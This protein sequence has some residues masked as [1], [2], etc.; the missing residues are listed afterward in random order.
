MVFSATCGGIVQGYSDIFVAYSTYK[1]IVL[2]YPSIFTA[3]S[4]DA[5]IFA[6]YSEICKSVTGYFSQLFPIYSRHIEKPGIFAVSCG[7]AYR[8]V[9]GIFNYMWFL[10]MYNNRYIREIFKRRTVLSL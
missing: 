3:Y 6:T 10:P 9:V 5:G 2:G 8:Q 1:G 7:P 4:K